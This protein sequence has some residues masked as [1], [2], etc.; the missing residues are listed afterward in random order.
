MIKVLFVCLGNI[1]RSPLAEGLFTAMI[2]KKGLAG[3]V[4]CDSAGTSNYHIGDSPDPRTVANAAENGLELNHKGRQIE[5]DDFYEYD[6]IIPMDD[7]NLRHIKAKAAMVG[8]CDFEV[9][10]MRYFDKSGFNLDVPDPYYGGEDGFQ[11]VYEILSRSNEH[12]LTFLIK[13]HQLEN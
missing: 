13:Q 10:K 11:K 7:S 12:F 4:Q 6:Y 9:Y 1:C 8:F 3:K 2:K 5:A